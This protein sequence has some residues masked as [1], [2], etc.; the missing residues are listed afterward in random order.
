MRIPN[1]DPAFWKNTENFFR[2]GGSTPIPIGPSVLLLDQLV[3]HTT[4]DQRTQNRPGEWDGG[5]VFRA[6]DSDGRGSHRT[7][8]QEVDQDAQ[9]CT[10][11]QYDDECFAHVRCLSFAV[12]VNGSR[13]R[14]PCGCE[15]VWLAYLVCRSVRRFSFAAFV[16]GSRRFPRVRVPAGIS[17]A[18][19]TI[20][21]THI[22]L[23]LPVGWAAEP[24]VCG[25]HSAMRVPTTFPYIYVHKN[26]PMVAA[27][28]AAV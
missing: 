4:D 28:A 3:E 12:A 21:A 13:P 7:C 10:R 11:C 20:H 16:N 5:R 25:V 2:G 8:T 22:F 6:R 15:C 14:V 19:C 26:H 24:L 1:P 27:V 9:C 17:F 18:I 23:P